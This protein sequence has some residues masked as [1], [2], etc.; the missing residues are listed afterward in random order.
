MLLGE[1][2]HELLAFALE[3]PVESAGPGDGQIA[4]NAVVVVVM[5]LEPMPC[6]S[7]GAMREGAVVN[8]AT[9]ACRMRAERNLTGDTNLDQISQKCPY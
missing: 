5:V 4:L 6:D 9:T 3:Q 7:A 2:G 8:R 1:V